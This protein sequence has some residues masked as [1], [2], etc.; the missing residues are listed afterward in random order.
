MSRRSAKVLEVQVPEVGKLTRIINKVASVV[1]EGFFI[2]VQSDDKN[3]KGGIVLQQLS[4][5][6][7]IY[8]DM[9]LESKYFDPFM[10]ADKTIRI[11]VDIKNFF[12]ALNLINA[13]VPVK[14]FMRRN[15]METLYIRSIEDRP[16]KIDFILITVDNQMIPKLVLDGRCKFRVDRKEFR[17]ICTELN[18]IVD[19]VLITIT[20]DTV[21]FNA[22]SKEIGIIE[23]SMDAKYLGKND[24]KVHG[25]YDVSKI[26]TFV[27]YIK[28]DDEIE[29]VMDND[30]PI[31]LLFDIPD[32]GSMKISFSPINSD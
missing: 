16:V 24:V 23:K 3:E 13:K 2:F 12:T 27:D 32:L 20:N 4:E 22:T 15:S 1:R 9:R 10:C 7:N 8:V 30:F 18:K 14:F 11:G 5:D 17:S 25:E 31:V 26:L 28:N 29:I 21:L 6:K 19:K